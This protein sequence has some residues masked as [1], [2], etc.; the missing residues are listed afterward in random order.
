MKNTTAIEIV[1]LAALLV[2]MLAGSAGIVY[3]FAYAANTQG[4]G[5]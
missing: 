4:R 5:F 2:G 1:K 3:L